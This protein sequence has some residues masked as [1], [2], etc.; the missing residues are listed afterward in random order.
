M[1]ISYKRK[2]ETSH[3][4]GWLV[5][6]CLLFIHFISYKHIHIH[7]DPTRNLFFLYFDT[8]IQSRQRRQIH[9]ITVRKLMAIRSNVV[10]FS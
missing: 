1:F 7:H 4:S 10:F 8:H 2:K 5:F 3:H 9:L 6:C